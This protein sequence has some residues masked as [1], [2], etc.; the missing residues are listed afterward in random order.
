MQNS[1]KAPNQPL[2]ALVLFKMSLSE[3]LTEIWCRR[4]AETSRAE[5]TE[6]CMT[7]PWQRKP[8]FVCAALV[9]WPMRWEKNVLFFG[10][11]GGHLL[12]LSNHNCLLHFLYQLLKSFLC[13]HSSLPDHTPTEFTVLFSK[14]FYH[15]NWD[16]KIMTAYIWLKGYLLSFDFGGILPEGIL[17]FMPCRWG[18][19]T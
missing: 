4:L 12:F 9:Y 2:L 3:A 17:L 16:A 8:R 15:I 1:C 6:V 19:E 11:K 10:V 13:F 5:L 18:T 7:L 14:S